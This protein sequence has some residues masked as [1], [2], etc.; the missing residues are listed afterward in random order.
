MIIAADFDVLV[1]ANDVL[2]LVT[3]LV[4]YWPAPI[5]SVALLTYTVVT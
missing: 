3:R 2:F 4:A 1:N 5:H